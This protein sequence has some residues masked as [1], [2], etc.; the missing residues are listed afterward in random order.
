[1]P[2]TTLSPEAHE[3][4]HLALMVLTASLL[5]VRHA[6]GQD[7]KKTKS[8]GV[9]AFEKSWLLGLFCQC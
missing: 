2:G 4:L 7:D 5:C 3:T 9:G 8:A 6:V 1:M